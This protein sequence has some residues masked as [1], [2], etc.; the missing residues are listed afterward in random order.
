[1]RKASAEREKALSPAA[2][3]SLSTHAL[4]QKTIPLVA[5]I[6]IAYKG[7]CP[8]VSETF[9]KA[10]PQRQTSGGPPDL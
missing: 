6:Y 7:Y 5:H 4:C 10:K 8:R 3:V 2:R 1:M 9:V